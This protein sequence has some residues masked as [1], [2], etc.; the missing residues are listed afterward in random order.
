MILDLI[1]TKRAIRDFS[2]EPVPEHIVREILEAGR[3]AQSSKND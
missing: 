2:S 3:L 1:R